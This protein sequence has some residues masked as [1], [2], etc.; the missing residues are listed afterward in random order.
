MSLALVEEIKGEERP[1]YFVSRIFKGAEIRYQKIEKLSLAVVTTARRLR[2][3]FQSHKIIVKTDHP[4]K[5]V[6]KKPNLARRMVVW[7]VELSEYDITF[8]P[9]DNIK[10]QILADFIL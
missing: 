9:R 10:L 6:L 7:A 4:I 5:H 8:V 3:Y 2:H 1:V